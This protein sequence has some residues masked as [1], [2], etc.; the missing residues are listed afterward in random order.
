MKRIILLTGYK[1]SGK[2]TAA[3]MFKEKLQEKNVDIGIIGIFAFADKLRDHLWALNPMVGTSPEGGRFDWRLALNTYGYDKAKHLFPDIRRLQQ[4]Y[5]TE[6]IR[7]HVGPDY[8]VEQ[9]LREIDYMHLDWALITDCRFVNEWEAVCDAA[10][11]AGDPEPILVE[12]RRP[13]LETEQRLDRHTSEDLR[14]V[15]E[16]D[17]RYVCINAEGDMDGL[18]VHCEKI[19]DVLSRSNKEI[20]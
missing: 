7:E 2:N 16:V 19:V 13:A 6:V 14:W 1:G 17:G 4:A 8:W 5:G 3:E 15:E 10:S 12:V 9:L 20:T 18:R 11:R